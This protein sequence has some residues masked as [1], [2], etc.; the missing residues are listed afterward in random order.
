[1]IALLSLILLTGAGGMARVPL[2]GRG[3]QNID[4]I[5]RELA[6][7]KSVSDF[8][9]IQLKTGSVVLRLVIDGD[10]LPMQTIIR[11][12]A[13]IHNQ[14]AALRNYADSFGRRDQVTSVSQGILLFSAHSRA[15]EFSNNFAATCLW[16]DPHFHKVQP[17]TVDL[18]EQTVTT[19]A[20]ILQWKRHAPLDSKGMLPR[21]FQV[22]RNPV[23]G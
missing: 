10:N 15:R 14:S 20:G 11:H 22:P 7:Y 5:A 21:L 13:L 19:S 9:G 16:H 17:W 12:L 3:N 6:K 23:Q 18:E 1:M 4:A 2:I 8:I